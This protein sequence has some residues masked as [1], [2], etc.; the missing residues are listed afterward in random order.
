[1]KEEKIIKILKDTISL[2]NNDTYCFTHSDNERVEAI[3][4]YIRFI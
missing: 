4:R 2:F 3:K 1:M